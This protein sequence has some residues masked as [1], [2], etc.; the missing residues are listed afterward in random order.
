MHIVVFSSILHILDCLLV[1][2]D[3]IGTFIQ[4]LLFFVELV[5]IFILSHFYLNFFHFSLT[6]NTV[7]MFSCVSCYHTSLLDSQT[8][9]SDV[10]ILVLRLD[11]LLLLPPLQTRLVTLETACAVCVSSAT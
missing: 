1:L 4:L 11:R 7:V 3:T 5:S 10:R 8:L 9:F 6:N 2:C